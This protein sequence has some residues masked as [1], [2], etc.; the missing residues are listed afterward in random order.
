MSK[1]AYILLAFS[2]ALVSVAEADGAAEV[3][4]SVRGLTADQT[5]AILAAELAGRRGELATAHTYYLQAAELTAHADLAELAVRAA[6]GDED[7]AGAERALALWLRLAPE[8]PEAHQLAAVLRI[9]AG[10]QEGALIHLR[11]IVELGALETEPAWARVSAIV[12]RVPDVETRLALMRALV[13]SF[14]DSADAEQAL[15]TVAAAAARYELADAAARRAL[16][17]R[18]DWNRP[19]LFL[20]KLLLS[21]NR[22]DEAR[23]L[24][25]S[26][27]SESPED[28]PLRMVYGQFLVEEQD[29]T[30]ARAVF[31]RL[32][33]NEPRQPD[34]LF[35]VG[36]LS[37]QLDDLDGARHAFTRLYDTG[38][39][40]D[41]AAYYLG[42]VEEHAG[43]VGQAID[44]YQQ[45]RDANA[46]DAQ[47]RIA[48]LEARA[49][50]VER[51]R[52]ILQRLRDQAPA[53]GLVLYLIE[54]EILVE[55]GE[56]SQAMEVFDAALRAYPND[57]DV[58]YARALHAVA[59]ERIDQAERDL[60]RIIADDPHH[61]DALNALGYTLAD[62]TERYEEA[63]VLIERAYAL[64]PEEPA[65]L[66]S[67]GWIQFRLGN[68][69]Q[70]LSYLRQALEALNDGE[71]AAHL[72]E[73]L[74]TMGREAEAWKVW[75]AALAEHP[76]H[77]YLKRVV[78]R[79]RLS[80]NTSDDQP[81][82][83]SEAAKP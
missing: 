48:L 23:A 83:S 52:E 43:H 81:R 5:F 73:V 17:L 8:S 72:G 75:E 15:A 67:M 13:E 16:A 42:Q 3:H 35:A 62:H 49:G 76:D 21:Q 46:S 2:L 69:E 82:Q 79:F 44:W 11:R 47:V 77:A 56:N 14:A 71:I 74:W 22:R 9:E 68:H 41:E 38:Q 70:A 51:A 33:H 58:L 40:R 10:D 28:S 55:A 78:E 6:M 57:P 61:A 31:E 26:F 20:V 65:I 54:A 32:L 37:L 7:R 80:R 24:L 1:Y 60:R 36:V 34:V 64:K 53:D 29:F 45:V 39:R 4:A 66:D 12:A 63:R 27:V 30:S 19:R 50:R 18:P 59:L 25:E